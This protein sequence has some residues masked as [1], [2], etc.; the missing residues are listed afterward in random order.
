MGVSKD[1]KIVQSIAYT[2]AEIVD[3]LGAGDTFVAAALSLLVKGHSLQDAITFGCK[4]AGAKI[5]I[6]GLKNLNTLC[7]KVNGAE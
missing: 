7:E 2:P 5:G 6:E 1:G 4:L 3:T